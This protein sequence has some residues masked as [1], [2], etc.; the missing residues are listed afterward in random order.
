MLLLVTVAVLALTVFAFASRIAWAFA[1]E[2]RVKD[3]NVDC[4]T[5]A[6]DGERM[7]DA[8][9]RGAKVERSLAEKV[10]EAAARCHLL[11]SNAVEAASAERYLIGAL[12]SL[13]MPLVCRSTTQCLAGK[14]CD[15][16][17]GECLER[18]IYCDFPA[19]CN[20][21]KSTIWYSNRTGT[22]PPTRRGAPAARERPSAREVGSCALLRPA[23]VEKSVPTL[24]TRTAT[25]A[26]TTGAWE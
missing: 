1:S 19:D 9:A 10:R 3:P 8:L 11:S 7:M 20:A 25:V 14:V 22:A 5:V 18:G 13:G 16:G 26:S 23:A 12:E 6:A 24:S 17:S 2:R 21:D 15:Q 4:R